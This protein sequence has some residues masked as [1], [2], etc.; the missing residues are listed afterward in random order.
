MGNRIISENASGDCRVLVLL[1][2][3]RV[4]PDLLLPRVDIQWTERERMFLDFR[5]VQ[6]A[7]RVR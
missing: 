1:R 7:R 2:L 6:A 4:A 3:E 5:T